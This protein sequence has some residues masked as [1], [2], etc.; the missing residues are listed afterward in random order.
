[1]FNFYLEEDDLGWCL[2]VPATSI[3]SLKY[4]H[5]AFNSYYGKIYPAHLIFYDCC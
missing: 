1:M 3:H 4:F 2:S 5:D